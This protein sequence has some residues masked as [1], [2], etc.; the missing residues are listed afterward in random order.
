MPAVLA[1]TGLSTSAGQD[2]GVIAPSTTVGA[3]HLT[4]GDLARSLSYYREA[5]GLQVLEEED[6]R[7]SLGVAGL[8]LLV[9]VEV[10]GAR[11]APNNTGLFH[12]AL[13]VPQRADLARWLAHAAQ[14]HVA[15]T[16]ASDHLVSEALYLHDPDHHGIE[17]YRDRQ[18][19][20]WENQV[21]KILT[22]LPLDQADL[23]GELGDP[24][25]EVFDGLPPGT[26]MGHIHLQVADIPAAVGFYRDR[27]G[28][29]LMATLGDQAAFLSAGGYH[30]HVG[31]N[32]WNSRG[33]SPPDPGAAALRLATIVL[34]DDGELD[35]VAQRV[36]E[37]GQEPEA[38]DGGL[39]VHDPSG[40]ALLLTTA[41]GRTPA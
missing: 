36:T 14:D 8:E 37:G 32:V 21:G 13:R 35:R 31:V 5:I 18:R 3:V 28:F 25:S 17:I 30:H 4:V 26:V 10:P 27:L 19:E 20:T 22:T 1:G 34:P 24:A 12:F 33:A 11:P 7:A 6:G 16:G 9:L 38:G 29:G 15:L 39:V 40:N 41:S 2:N 23:F